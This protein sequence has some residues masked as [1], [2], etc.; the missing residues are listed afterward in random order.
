MI[1]S[2]AWRNIWRNKLRSLIIMLS[3]AL[4][5]FAGIAIL[6]L[7][8]GMIKSRVRTVIDR[9]VGHIQMHH[10][11]FKKD[12]EAEYIIP[13]A[14]MIL[15]EVGTWPEVRAIT[16]RTVS[17]SMLTTA[18]GASGI[19]VNGIRWKEENQVSH[20]TE[21]IIEGKP[22]DTLSRHQIILSKKL[23]EKLK[24]HIGNKVILT[25]TDKNH[26]I[27]SGAFKVTGIYQTI[28]TPL[29]ERNVYV[30]QS[31]LNLLLN[32]ESLS[33]EMAI[34][35]QDDE[36]LEE[37]Q[38][39]LKT[40][41]PSLQVE[42]W[43]E[44]S[45]ETELM[46]ASTDQYMYIFIIIIMLALAFGII[47]TMLMAIL[48]RV[49]ELGMMT[50]LG[51]NK[52]RLFGLILYETVLLTLAGVPIGI[53]MAWTVTSYFARH[54]IDLSSVS[55]ESMSSFGFESIIYPEFPYEKLA[56]VLT[57]VVVTAVLASILPSLKALSLRPA[58]ALSK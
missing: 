49:R 54:G 57:I 22:L 53:L 25:L 26:T 15:R 12:Y 27:N 19:Q 8:K 10:K 51:F 46:V 36:I 47:N 45:P 32:T 5:V 2:L 48:E 28:N 42:N 7:Y 39:K 52:L 3:V 14:E 50:A 9:E 58:E 21:K 41:F 33:H 30:N 11:D 17:P 16:S 24:I 18:T 31:D 34:V 37:V 55:K 4:G 44:I 20:I 43:K 35:L 56:M 38:L 29:D 40:H 1:L 23:S 13:D 6:A